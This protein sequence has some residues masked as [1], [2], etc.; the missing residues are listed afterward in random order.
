[1]VLIWVILLGVLRLDVQRRDIPLDPH[2]VLNPSNLLILEF[3]YVDTLG[4]NTF[5]AEAFNFFMHLVVLEV[6]LLFIDTSVHVP[7]K[8]T[9]EQRAVPILCCFNL[10]DIRVVVTV[11]GK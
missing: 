5:M 7:I 11:H 8:K 2:R 4:H 1:M 3:Y 6:E 9:G 10:V